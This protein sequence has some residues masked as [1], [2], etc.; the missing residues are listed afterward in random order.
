L[1]VRGPARTGRAGVGFLRDQCRH[2]VV[3]CGYEHQPAPRIYP[4]LRYDD[5][6]EAIRF[7]THAFGFTAPDLAQDPDGRV[8]HALVGYEGGVVMLSSRRNEPSPFDQ[9]T[10]CLYVA[11]DDPD[12]HHRRAV[13]AGAEVIMPLTD[14]PYGSREYAARDPEGNVWVFGTYH[15][16]AG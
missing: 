6:P 9:G 13:E 10:A 2:R 5:A 1:A 16:V 3:A 12:A 7:L 4:T 11:V 15:P 14:Q 8:G